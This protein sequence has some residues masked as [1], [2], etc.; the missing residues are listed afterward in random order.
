MNYFKIIGLFLL[1][2]TIV[3][4]NN[5]AFSQKK[6]KKKSDDEYYT[7]P[8]SEYVI[9][10]DGKIYPI[11]LED[12]YLEDESVSIYSN[13]TLPEL[14]ETENYSITITAGDSFPLGRNVF[15]QDNY[16]EIDRKLFNNEKL[17]GKYFSK[18]DTCIVLK[19]ANGATKS[20]YFPSFMDSLSPTMALLQQ[21]ELKSRWY[22]FEGYIKSIDAYLINWLESKT[23]DGYLLVS[24]KDGSEIEW[25]GASTYEYLITEMPI[26]SPN[27][28]QVLF[29]N[30]NRIKF[31]S[32][33]N[34]HFKQEFNVS[35]FEDYSWYGHILETKW[36]TENS[37]LMYIYTY[38]D[39]IAD[40]VKQFKRVT[41]TKK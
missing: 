10:G 38:D 32:T 21:Y 26:I 1:T 23:L 30:N 35:F 36:E 3:A 34:G 8:R 13:Y 20:Y 6:K 12:D 14:I 25:G 18:K 17:Y 2:L 9:S 4:T 5:D 28:E 15:F 29:V 16:K 7:V 22:Y 41:I 33:K 40:Y 37:F 19:L 39:S 31:Y 24:A 11:V 27:N